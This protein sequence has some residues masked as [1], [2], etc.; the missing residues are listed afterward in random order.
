MIIRYRR[1]GKEMKALEEY[2]TNPQDNKAKRKALRYFNGIDDSIIKIHSRLVAADNALMYNQ[3]YA[4]GN[5]IEIKQGG[6]D[7]TPLVLKLRVSNAYR[8]FFHSVDDNNDNSLLLIKNWN[9]QFDQIRTIVV[10]DLN[11]HNYNAV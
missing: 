1:A 5:K 2:M 7:N 10:I 11:K 9:N 3:I 8:K 6:R 4:Q